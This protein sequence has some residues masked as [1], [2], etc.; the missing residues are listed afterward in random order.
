M[1]KFYKSIIPALTFSF[2]FTTVVCCCIGKLALAS[3]TSNSCCH[4]KKSVSGAHFQ[5]ASQDPASSE[6]PARTFAV[7]STD[8]SE[9][10]PELTS[11]LNKDNG[12]I[13]LSFLSN[14]H[15]LNLS[16]IGF[17]PQIASSKVSAIP[18]YLKNSI[19]RI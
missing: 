8:K 9:I 12:K 10:K 4:T 7:V 16:A 17:S 2:F 6:C 18:L 11:S 1:K 5:I 13:L 3:A 14:H 19:L 15:S